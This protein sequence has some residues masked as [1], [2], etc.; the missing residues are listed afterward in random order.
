MAGF[1]PAAL[2]FLRC[3]ES[4]GK[5]E[6]VP[7]PAEVARTVV[8]KYREHFRDEVPVADEGLLCERS[9]R[10][11]PIVSEIPLLLKDESLPATV[12]GPGAGT[13]A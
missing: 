12:L 3:P 13:T 5:L 1:N 2:E 7:L 4:G 9:G 6:L 8:D 10:L 11:Y